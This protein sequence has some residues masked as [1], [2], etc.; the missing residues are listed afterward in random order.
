MIMGIVLASLTALA[1]CFLG[2]SLLAK[3]FGQERVER[4][5]RM[6]MQGPFVP[7]PKD[8]KISEERTTH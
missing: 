8:V 2:L 1:F 4:Y 3:L 6:R 7:T 5:I